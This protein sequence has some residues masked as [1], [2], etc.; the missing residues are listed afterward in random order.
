MKYLCHV[1]APIITTIDGDNL[2]GEP[3]WER[4]VFDSFIKSGRDVHSTFNIWNSEEPKPT[5]FHDG[6]NAAW[7]ND[8]ILITHG[9]NDG[10]TNITQRAKYYIV[11]Y[12]DG[13]TNKNKDGFLK[14][15]IE[16]PGCIFATCSYRSWTYLSSLQKVL[17]SEN[18]E[19]I[20]GPSVPYVVDSAD[21]FK[22][23]NLYWG[24]RNFLEY[25]RKDVRLTASYI[26]MIGKF[27]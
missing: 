24:H 4:N 17:G 11:Q 23:P 19:C 15:N 7:Q 25:A 26:N 10:T 8:S 22:K 12:F 16:K 20:H 18:V 13:P 3:R 2:R 9:G 1:T 27:L 6:V 14:Y 5:N 21:N